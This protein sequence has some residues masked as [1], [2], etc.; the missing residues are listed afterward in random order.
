K[1]CRE[2][3]V[4]KEYILYE[5]RLRTNSLGVFLFLHT[6]TILIHCILMLATS[7]VGNIPFYKYDRITLLHFQYPVLIYIDVILYLSASIF[8]ILVLSINFNNQI[9]SKHVWVAYFTSAISVLT[10]AAVDFLLHLY[11]FHYN[12][13]IVT[14]SFNIY[15]LYMTYL[16]LPIP[17]IKGPVMLGFGIS[18]VYMAF[19]FFFL[20]IKYDTFL[21]GLNKYSNIIADVLH[22]T[23]FNLLGAFFRF[24]NDITV[25]SSI[26]D[27]HQ[28][29][30]EERWHKSARA[31][32]KRLLDSILPPQIAQPIQDNIRL[33][34]AASQKQRDLA[35]TMSGRVMGIQF[36]P[37]VSILYADVV[38]YTHL[39]T[40]LTVQEL[41]ALL[42]DLFGRFDRAAHRFEVQRI[43]FLG[44]C[45]YCVAGLMR[46]HPDHAK[47]C[48]ELGHH[49]IAHIRE[50]RETRN[51]DIDMRIGVHS[52]SLLAGV[53]GEAKV[54]FD[55]WG[56]DVLIANKLES[57]GLPGHIH[58]S[59]R[60]LS[61]LWN[62]TY[63][64]LPG[65]QEARE[66]PFLLQCGVQTYL[67]AYIDV[68]NDID[69]MND[70]TK[71]ESKT[72]ANETEK[73]ERLDEDL[74][75]EF[76]SMPVGTLTWQSIFGKKKKDGKGIA[77]QPIIGVY[78]LQ[79]HDAVLEYN[80][81]R[82]PDYLLKYSVLLSWWV[83]VALIYEQ[84]SELYG[85]NKRHIMPAIAMTILTFILFVTWYKELCYWWFGANKSNYSKFSCF[86]FK[87]V[88]KL[89]HSIIA[90]IFIYVL[91][92]ILYFSIMASLLLRCNPDEFILLQIESKIYFYELR[93]EGCF[94]PWVLTKMMCL[95][96]GMSWKY[97]GIPFTMK[98]VITVM[99]TFTYEILMC[100]HYQYIYHSSITTNPSFIPEYS[101]SLFII[102]TW[103]TQYTMERE[104]EFNNKMN[105]NWRV[106]LLR[107]QQEAHLTNKSIIILLHN[108][109]PTHVVNVYLTSLEKHEL[110]YESF[111][112]V[113]VMFASLHNF[114]LKIPNLRLLNEVICEFDRI[115]KFYKS[116]YLVEKIKIVGCTYMAAC[117]LDLRFSGVIKES[118]RAKNSVILEVNEAQRYMSIFNKNYKTQ[119]VKNEEVVFVLTTFALDL[120][121]TLWLLRKAY[122]AM[123]LEWA[124][125]NSDMTVGISSGEVMAGVVG[126]SQVHYDIW[127]NAVNMASRMDST[128]MPGRIQVT[129][130]SAKVL[131][132]CGVECVFRGQTYVKGRGMTPTYF[133]EIDDN[134]EFKNTPEYKNRTV[135]RTNKVRRS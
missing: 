118:K 58:I 104:A 59:G 98:T 48:V 109:L 121:R 132:K 6:A 10:L 28:Y 63:E 46:P 65:T 124:V 60:T 92:I 31:H 79:F 25:R 13:W 69:D 39:T 111:E 106:E 70:L 108:I 14:F 90:R 102:V 42:H 85:Q 2:V 26:L 100:Y 120:M 134:L 83:L 77:N 21:G 105:Y 32:E 112:M 97:T 15:V 50:V 22:Y 44:D 117:G 73:R 115:L 67:I 33:R 123:P 49:M 66:N 129:E 94:H 87:V 131:K 72:E 57:T 16:F 81:M 80:Y 74:R 24:V 64:I 51:L 119:N 43:K 54:Q 86:L 19:F 9:V 62:E 5:R 12:D 1:K 122:S 29:V 17:G 114:E 38:N 103:I 75:K 41:V 89:K 95:V 91:T 56:E 53:I 52:G 71:T 11:H 27:R 4:E 88:E 20:A 110:Y 99:E 30:M 128:G 7:A 101:Q 55:I 68:S 125:F 84:E 47:K 113:A 96:I 45:Y 93:K 3:G 107:M 23:S 37:D 116:H 130:E 18:A 133:V 78:F 40:T 61:H 34:I 35:S 76:A 82:Q 126:A 127:G 36:H 8:I 135:F